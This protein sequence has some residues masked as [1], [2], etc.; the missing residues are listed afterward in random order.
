MTRIDFYHE[1]A[2]RLNVA[3]RLADKA[4]RQNLRVVIYAPDATLAHTID[5]LLW[6][7]VPIAFVPHCM[8]QHRLAAETPVLIAHDDAPTPQHDNVLINLHDE[9]PPAF[10]RFERLVEIVS[11]EEADRAHARARFRF[12]K[13]RGYPI[14]A[15]N[16]AERRH[17]G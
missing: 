7:A 13:D 12:Y 3:C 6:T 10:A 17:G 8:A 9:W 11:R 5:Q 14:Q 4:V 2:D 16:L 1:A 15:H